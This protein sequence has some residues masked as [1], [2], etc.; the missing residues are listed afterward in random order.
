V[1]NSCNCAASSFL[2]DSP[3]ESMRITA[4]E[5]TAATQSLIYRSNVIEKSYGQDCGE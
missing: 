1:Y 5:T 3:P 4:G 2:S